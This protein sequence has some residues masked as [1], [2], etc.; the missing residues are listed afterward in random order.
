MLWVVILSSNE[1]DFNIHNNQ[2]LMLWK[3]QTEKLHGTNKLSR[4]M[5]NP[6]YYIRKIVI[7]RNPFILFRVVKTY[8]IH[9]TDT[10]MGVLEQTLDFFFFFLFSRKNKDRVM[11]FIYLFREVNK[12]TDFLPKFWSWLLIGYTFQ[13][14]ILQVWSWQFVHIG[15][16]ETM[17][18]PYNFHKKTKIIS[19][20]NGRLEQFN[21]FLALYWSLQLGDS[22]NPPQI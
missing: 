15:D 7:K 10:N 21:C 16:N 12:P 1:V 11:K 17:I 3:V 5:L 6:L 14:C 13:I 18:R 22:R 8:Q 9:D 2:N 20:I 4:Y 19:H